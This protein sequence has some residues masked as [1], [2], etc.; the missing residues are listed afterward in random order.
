VANE[1]QKQVERLNVA[2]SRAQ[3]LTQEKSRISGEL[4]A[5]KKREAEL[6]KRCK[7][8]LDCAVSELPALMKQLEQEAEKS[9]ANAEKVLGLRDGVPEPAGGESD[10]SVAPIEDDEPIPDDD[11]L[12]V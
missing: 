9:L 8:E 7:E 5:L 4:N 6:E 1:V 12:G 11:G 3:E 10:D 2:R